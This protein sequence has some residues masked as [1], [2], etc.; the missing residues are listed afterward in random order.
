V[1]TN[2]IWPGSDV[3]RPPWTTVSLVAQR[4]TARRPVICGSSIR[5]SVSAYSLPRNSASRRSRVRASRMRR[6]ATR[7]R[8]RADIA[9]A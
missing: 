3:R 4:T 7:S 5:R 1:S 8:S 9:A 6:A 2:S